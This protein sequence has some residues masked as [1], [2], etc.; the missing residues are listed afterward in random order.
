MHTCCCTTAQAGVITPHVAWCRALLLA[1]RSEGWVQSTASS[2]LSVEVGAE[3]CSKHIVQGGG[4]R[5]LLPA[6]RSAGW[7]HSTAP[8]TSTSEVGSEH[9]FQ[10]IVQRGGCRGLLPGKRVAGSSSSLG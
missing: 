5:A 10:P 4:C 1:D 6:D 9:S 8:S 2:T 3:H 7:V